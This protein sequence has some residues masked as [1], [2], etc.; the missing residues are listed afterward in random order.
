MESLDSM[1]NEH[2]QVEDSILST[3]L[4]KIGTK[5]IE[6]SPKDSDGNY[7]FRVI[8]MKYV[9]GISDKTW[10]RIL[11]ELKGLSLPLRIRALELKPSSDELC[12]KMMAF[13]ESDDY[14]SL[15]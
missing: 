1:A 12:K 10:L 7:V 6:I 2:E 3:I 8:H 14:K 4:A 15:D 11:K 9:A 5:R 13:L